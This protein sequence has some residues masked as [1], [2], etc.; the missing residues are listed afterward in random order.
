MSYRIFLERYEWMNEKKANKRNKYRSEM[1]EDVVR[2]IYFRDPSK[3][4]KHG[5]P[6]FQIIMRNFDADRIHL[7]ERV[8]ENGRVYSKTVWLLRE[9]CEKILKNDLEWMARRESVIFDLYYHIVHEGYRMVMMDE[10]TERI[11]R[12]EKEGK[13]T[14]IEKNRRQ[15]LPGAGS[16]FEEAPEWEHQIR[17]GKCRV[18][19]QKECILPQVALEMICM[20]E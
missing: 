18:V 17:Q 11:I 14:T 20:P 9:D 5:R 15:I 19:E 1:K 7:E 2:R 4:R 12:E 3:K 6:E 10:M 8:S 13:T 16:F